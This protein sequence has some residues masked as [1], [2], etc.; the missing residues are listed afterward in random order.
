MQ[1]SAAGKDNLLEISKRGIP[2]VGSL[3]VHGTSTLVRTPKDKDERRSG[4]E[5]RVN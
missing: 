5:D 4:S 3:L 2:Y 1:Q